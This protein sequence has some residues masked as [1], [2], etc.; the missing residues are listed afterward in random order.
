MTKEEISEAFA[1]F[2]INQD[3]DVTQD[4]FIR[5]LEGNNDWIYLLENISILFI[6]RKGYNSLN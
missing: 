3:G 5:V 1:T 6:N 4:E 2:D